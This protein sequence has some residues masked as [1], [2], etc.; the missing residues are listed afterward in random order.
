MDDSVVRAMAKWHDVRPGLVS[1]T[2]VCGT[3]RLASG[4]GIITEGDTWTT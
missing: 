3:G 2:P 1:G 4:I